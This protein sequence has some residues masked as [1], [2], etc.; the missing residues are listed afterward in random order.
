MEV[1]FLIVLL[2]LVLL[3]LWYQGGLPSFGCRKEGLGRNALLPHW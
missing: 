3:L 2:V 1:N